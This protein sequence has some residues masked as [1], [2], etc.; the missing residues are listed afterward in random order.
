[1]E[2]PHGNLAEG[3]DHQWRAKPGMFAE[4][5]NCLALFFVQGHQ[6]GVTVTVRGLRFLAD[7]IL[8]IRRS[9]FYIWVGTKLP[10]V[11]PSNRKSSRVFTPWQGVSLLLDKFLIWMSVWL[12]HDAS[13]V[14]H[15]RTLP[16]PLRRSFCYTARSY[17]GG[18]GTH[19]GRS[20]MGAVAGSRE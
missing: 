19:R 12:L 8:G 11:C 15:N 18:R 1:M 2:A 16:R 3:Y 13:L 9:H 6:A 7:V 14:V 17:P 20:L 10:P 5:L 4:H